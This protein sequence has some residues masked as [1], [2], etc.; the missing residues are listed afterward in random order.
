MPQL[1]RRQWFKRAAT[2]GLA[3]TSTSWLGGCTRPVDMQEVGFSVFGQLWRLRFANTDAALINEAVSLA[4]SW[5]EPLYQQIHPYKESELTAV[6]QQLKQHGQA[7]LTPTLIELYNASRYLFEATD[8]LF[9]PSIGR[10]IALWGFHQDGG[11]GAHQPPKPEVLEEWQKKAVDLAQTRLEGTTLYT[12]NSAVA[13]DFNAIAEGFAVSHLLGKLKALGVQN[14]LIDPGGD[15][16]ALGQA[17]RRSWRIGIE[18]PRKRR[19]M[20]SIALADGESIATSGDYEHQFEYQGQRFGHIIHPK[21]AY[22][23][24]RL[25]SVTTTGAKP[26]YCDGATTALMLTDP[27]QDQRLIEQI[28]QRCQLSRILMT[29]LHGNHWANQAML[30]SITP[31]ED[32]A[33]ALADVRLL[34]G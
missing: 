11:P 5:V 6:N 31:A 29:D 10:L 22:P 21:T 17:G 8:G 13:F 26:I 1:T 30:D 15:I 23:A 24:E 19:V 2:A 14:C 32:A 4:E 20:G 3:L 12:D 7:E 27:E 18:H 28:M 9:D 16:T 33:W 25:A 34:D